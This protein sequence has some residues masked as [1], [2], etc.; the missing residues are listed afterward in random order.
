MP[1][2]IAVSKCLAASQNGETNRTKPLDPSVLELANA[3][4]ESG[5]V[6][7]SCCEEPEHEHDDEQR[8]ES[9]PAVAKTG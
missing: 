9:R 4:G 6:D 3:R 2:K 5:E 7:N 8:R 1:A